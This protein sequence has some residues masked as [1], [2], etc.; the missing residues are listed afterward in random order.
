MLESL[1]VI[2]SVE[3]DDSLPVHVGGREILGGG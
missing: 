3:S 2:V 1:L